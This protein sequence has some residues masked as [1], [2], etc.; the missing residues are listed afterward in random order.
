MNCITNLGYKIKASYIFTR[1]R[2]DVLYF[3]HSGAI[4]ENETHH[5]IMLKKK[6][7]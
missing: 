3:S 1:S 5:C 2:Y 6:L 7:N 4:F